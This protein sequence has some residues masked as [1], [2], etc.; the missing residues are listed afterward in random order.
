MG[1]PYFVQNTMH[2]SQS[3]ECLDYIQQIWSSFYKHL[4]TDYMQ[5]TP[6][7]PRFGDAQTSFFKCVWDRLWPAD[8]LCYFLVFCSLVSPLLAV[9]VFTHCLRIFCTHH[10]FYYRS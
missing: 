8:V 7:L 1:S 5:K 3:L 4:W 2:C 9:N 10:L 6:A